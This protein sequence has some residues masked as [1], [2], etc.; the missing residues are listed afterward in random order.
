VAFKIKHHKHIFSAAVEC[1]D[2]STLTLPMPEGMHRVQR[3]AYQRVEAPRNRSVLATF[4]DGGLRDGGPP[5]DLPEW[6][7]WLMDLSAGGFQVRVSSRAAPDMEVGDVVA[8]RIDLGQDYRPIVA[9][10]QFRHEVRDERGVA[11][12]GFQ[13]VGLNGSAAGREN[14]LR[15]GQIVCEFQRLE[16]RQRGRRHD[17]DRAGARR[18]TAG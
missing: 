18:Q 8:V 10:A 12:M 5:A 17:R 16:G 2:E 7:G 11:M 1:C 4:W 14:L 9:D 15:I 3:R 6:E 13:F